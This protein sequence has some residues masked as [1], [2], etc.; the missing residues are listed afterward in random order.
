MFILF[1]LPG[2]FRQLERIPLGFMAVILNGVKNLW[3]TQV[4]TLRFAQGDNP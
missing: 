3:L 4:E 1:F 2:L